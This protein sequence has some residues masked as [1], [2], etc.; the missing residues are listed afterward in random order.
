[1]S[2]VE[3]KMKNLRSHLSTLQA[4]AGASQ[5]VPGPL[6]LRPGTV[7]ALIV[8]LLPPP[9]LP[10]PTACRLLALLAAL[11]SESPEEAQWAA[12]RLLLLFQLPLRDLDLSA[13]PAFPAPCASSASVIL[14]VTLDA[15][16]L[17]GGA[18]A[19]IGKD[20][21]VTLTPCAG[22]RTVNGAA[23]VHL[24]MPRL[25][26]GDG[27]VVLMPR[28]VIAAVRDVVVIMPRLTNKDVGPIIWMAR[29]A[30]LAVGDAVSAILGVVQLPSVAAM[31]VWEDEG[32]MWQCGVVEVVLLP[33]A[34]AESSG[35]G[36]DDLVG[37]VEVILLP[38]AA[39]ESAGDGVDDL[40]GVVEAAAP[41]P[42]T[43]G[44]PALSSLG[45]RLL[46]RRLR[47]GTGEHRLTLR[48]RN[49][50]PEGCSIKNI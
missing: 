25:T 7:I 8:A 27:Q 35:D 43:G 50:Q 34:A 46:A 1:M 11:G 22:A 36:V 18:S 33:S 13:R 29:G 17:H 20:V 37:D 42:W 48:H 30:I 6:V 47:V 15:A 32:V 39:A 10:S 14:D 41:G 24:A 45:P 9:V 16:S 44:R 3:N 28:V 40:V 4:R 31:A 21:W 12:L 2:L 23:L 5:G 19:V 38:R 26:A 49:T